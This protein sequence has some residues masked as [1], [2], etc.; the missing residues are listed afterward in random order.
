MSTAT[1]RKSP[2]SS[3]YNDP[4]N[5]TTNQVPGSADAAQ[6]GE[7]TRADISV[8]GA[9]DIGGW[10]FKPGS[11][12][13]D[14][15]VRNAAFVFLSFFGAGI[16]ARGDHVNISVEG[17]SGLFGI[18]GMVFR[19]HSTAGT[20][21]ISTNPYADLVFDNMSTA[22]KANISN[23]G[24]VL[25][26]YNSS[27]GG[28]A[29]V[30]LAS[31][32]TDFSNST[33]PAANGE[34]TAGSIAGAGTYELGGDRLTV[35]LNGRSTEVSGPIEDGGHF[36]GSGASLVK[37]GHGTL[38]LSHAGNSYSGG[39][40]IEQGTLDI[41]AFAAAGTG[42]ITFKGAAEL[43][44]KSAALFE[45]V[46]INPIMSFG[47]HDAID[48]TELKFHRGAS[49]RY[50]SA[51]H[52]LTVHSGEVTDALVL[53]SPKGTHFAVARDGH[54]GTEVTLRHAHAAAVAS[55]AD[56]IVAAPCL[57]APPSLCSAR[58]S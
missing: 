14:F 12:H 26:A 52:V 7:S 8:I 18:A 35:G 23:A 13:Y 1:W 47:K 57:A 44:I 19:N 54:G 39:T 15:T 9:D 22:G 46:F 50:D 29:I 11:L 5:W 42:E 6:F 36:G 38:K 45:D 10:I 33:G 56:G 20:A 30:T 48:L 17:G 40:T 37:T 24:T 16:V 43:E 2:G 3:D 28:A 55:P 27:G 25:F 21:S 4:L 34:L 41:T 49:A 58:R 51:T 53:F 32:T 31:G